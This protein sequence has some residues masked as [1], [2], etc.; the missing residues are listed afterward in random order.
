D[1][2]ELAVLH[3]E[4]DPDERAV[5]AG[6]VEH[7][8][9]LLGVVGGIDREAE[10]PPVAGEPYR[11]QALDPRAPSLAGVAHA[12]ACGERVAAAEQQRDDAG[13]RGASPRGGTYPSVQVAGSPAP[14]RGRAPAI[15][16]RPYGASSA[17]GWTPRGRHDVARPGSRRRL[18][19]RVARGITGP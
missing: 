17:T 10:Q 7:G 13:D 14:D 9:D 8:A 3:A 2:V 19:P 5:G 1:T 11:F 15:G 18:Y 6:E 12:V 16:I 4:V